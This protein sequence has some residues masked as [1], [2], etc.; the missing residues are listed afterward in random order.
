VDKLKYKKTKLGASLYDVIR[1]GVMNLDSGIGVY[2]PDAESY[3][4]FA[5]LFDGIIQEYHGF[6]PKDRQP[7]VDLGEGKYDSFPPLDPSGQYIV[8]TRY[9]LYVMLLKCDTFRI[10]CGRSIRGYPFNPLLTGD[11]YM[12]MQQK[13]KK[14]LENIKEKDLQGV[15]YPLAG[16]TKQVQN[17]LIEGNFSVSFVKLF[18]RPLF[19]QRRRPLFE[20]SQRLQLLADGE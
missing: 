11:D 6:S 13:V 20:G 17:Q 2:A 5:P 10:R 7:P 15:Y 3:T 19:V 4:T 16:M 18:S 9:V 12:I 14:A 8:S 1:S